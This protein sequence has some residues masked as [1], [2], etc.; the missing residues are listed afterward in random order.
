MLNI[1]PQHRL[2]V[3]ILPADFR[4]GI[5]ALKALCER[6]WQNDPFAGAIF[7]FRNLSYTS[8]KPLSY[9]GSGFWLCQKRFSSGKLAWWPTTDSEAKSL[10]AIELMIMLQQGDPREAN[11]PLA[12]RPV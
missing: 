7:I 5:D 8:V 10:R 12:W 2:F 11:V 1:T 3:A 6:Q 4:K 9:D